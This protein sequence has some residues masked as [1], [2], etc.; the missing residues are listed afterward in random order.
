MRNAFIISDCKCAKELIELGWDDRLLIK[1]S[2]CKL[3]LEHCKRYNMKF[4]EGSYGT[5]VHKHFDKYFEYVGVR[6]DEEYEIQ[7]KLTCEKGLN[8]DYR[9]YGVYLD[10]DHTNLFKSKL[11]DDVY[12]LSS[13]PYGTL[14]GESIKLLK[15]YPYNVFVINPNFLD[16]HGFIGR[17][18]MK[19]RHPLVDVNYAFTNATEEQMFEIEKQMMEDKSLEVFPIF[20]EMPR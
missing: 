18:D 17:F 14:S 10:L 15:H 1:P 13:S 19:M 11:H 16:Y 20:R 4:L 5:I 7:Q 2:D 6:T 3:Y 12:M 9:V 8:E